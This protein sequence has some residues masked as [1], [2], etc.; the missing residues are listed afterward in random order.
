[1]KW[2]CAKGLNTKTWGDCYFLGK[3]GPDLGFQIGALIV[4]MLKIKSVSPDIHYLTPAVE[5]ASCVK[6]KSRQANG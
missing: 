6:S 5:V 2:K 1:M 3:N 4:I